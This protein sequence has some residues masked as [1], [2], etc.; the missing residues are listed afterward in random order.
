MQTLQKKRFFEASFEEKIDFL[1]SIYSDVNA[2]SISFEERNKMDITDK[3][4]TYGEVVFTEIA[5]ILECSGPTNGK[6]FYDLGS[7]SG[8]ACFAASFL[9][10]FEAVIGI[11]YLFNLHYLSDGIKDCVAETEFAPYIENLQFINGDIAQ[12]DF[13]NGDVLF[14]NSTC[15]S[16]ELFDT[17]CGKIEDLKIGSQVILT[18][19]TIESENFVLEH[20]I[21]E[22]QFSWGKAYVRIYQK[23][24]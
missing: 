20:E 14:M 17:I 11:E 13:S 9:F 15:Y 3:S 18:S 10:N 8:K 2:F 22:A 5:K 24:A 16:D 4:F 21:A 23:I 7:G 1:S 6:V 12:E 19:R